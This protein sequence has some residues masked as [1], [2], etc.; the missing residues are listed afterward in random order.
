ML[1]IINHNRHNDRNHL[2]SNLGGLWAAVLL[3]RPS[4]SPVP[5]TTLPFRTRCVLARVTLATLRAFA[6]LGPWRPA[7]VSRASGF[8]HFFLLGR[9]WPTA[10][11]CASGFCHICVQGAWGTS[12]SNALLRRSC[13]S[14]EGWRAKPTKL[15]RDTLR[16]DK[17][18]IAHPTWMLS[19]PRPSLR[20]N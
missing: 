13:G 18:C 17:N 3:H 19:C 7:A 11:F 4:H 20:R 15:A 9:G 5:I 6:S 1:I 14:E 10:H 8:C 16:G 12:L 2:G